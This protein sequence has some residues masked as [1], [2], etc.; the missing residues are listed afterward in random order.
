MQFLGERWCYFTAG[1]AEG[2]SADVIEQCV[3][4][5]GTDLAVVNILVDHTIT[6]IR[7]RHMYQQW[8]KVSIDP[9]EPLVSTW[10]KFQ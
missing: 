3:L 5:E 8:T 4:A 10:S 7:L 2:L 1:T 9:K 6:I